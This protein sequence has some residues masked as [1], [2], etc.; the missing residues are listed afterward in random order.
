MH[1]LLKTVWGLE[2]LQYV[3]YRVVKI[4]LMWSAPACQWW[5]Q[6]L[7]C[8]VPVLHSF[9]STPLASGMPNCR[10]LRWAEVCG[11][12]IRQGP[13]EWLG[14]TQGLRAVWELAEVTRGSV[15]FGSCIGLWKRGVAGWCRKS[16]SC[17]QYN[18]L[19][20]CLVERDPQSAFSADFGCFLHVGC[21]SSPTNWQKNTRNLEK[22]QESQA[23][24]SLLN[25]VV[26]SRWRLKVVPS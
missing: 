25:H 18:I 10:R 12:T 26:F 7:K 2:L 6:F 24:R 16:G 8:F 4:A 11:A 5:L 23:F 21:V 17:Q 13:S 20:G 9:C 19:E 14:S 3:S 22:C 15:G 1:N